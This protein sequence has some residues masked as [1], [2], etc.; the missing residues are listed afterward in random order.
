L[1]SDALKRL[2]YKTILTRNNDIYIPLE[3]RAEMANSID[4]DLFVSIH[5]NFS[6]SQ[7][8]EGIEVYY[9]KEEK[10]PLPFRIVQSKELGQEVLRKVIKNTGAESRGVKQANFAVIR[11]TKM[12]AV[13]VEA[14]FL[15]NPKER[16]KLRDQKYLE[17]VAKGIAHGVDQYLANHRKITI[18]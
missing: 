17:A 8:A 3:T 7:E 10:R 11:E 9:Y 5:Y 13:L 2:G 12:P 14:G 15:S 16:E 4:A 6:S 18:K 1:I